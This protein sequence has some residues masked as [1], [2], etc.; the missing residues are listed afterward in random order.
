MVGFCPQQRILSLLTVSQTHHLVQALAAE[1][2]REGSEFRM[3]EWGSVA[4]SP[5]PAQP[6]PAQ[7][8]ICIPRRILAPYPMERSCEGERR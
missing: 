6:R 5:G 1:R 7:A 4:G 8:A 3:P 2:P